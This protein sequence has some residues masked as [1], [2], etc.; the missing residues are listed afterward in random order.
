MAKKHKA[1]TKVWEK[2]RA[3]V[4][5]IGKARVKVGIL[6]GGATTDKGVR[7]VDI[8]AFHEFGTETIPKRSWLG[9]TMK[10]KH[11]EILEKCERIAR[12]LLA[13]K[14]EVEKAMNILGAYVANLVK[15]SI[16]TRL[17]KQEL[18][19]ATL[20]ERARKGD[21]NPRA[22]LDNGRLLGSIT[23]GVTKKEK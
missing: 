1:D 14:L 9:F 10:E 20:L 18:A 3:H 22:L 19:P 6:D 5:D 23:W 4:R 11:G 8:G 7:I 13:D 21:K 2:L 15:R 16:Q 17:I 12:L